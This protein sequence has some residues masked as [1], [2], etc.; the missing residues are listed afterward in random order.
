MTNVA[1]NKDLEAKTGLKMRS[2][3][4]PCKGGGCRHHESG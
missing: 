2:R 3:K 4:F 1:V